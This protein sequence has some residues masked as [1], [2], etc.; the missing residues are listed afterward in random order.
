MSSGGGVFV[1][2]TFTGYLGVEIKV[3]D[4]AV[5][6][7]APIRGPQRAEGFDLA[8]TSA[9]TMLMSSVLR[10]HTLGF[11]LNMAVF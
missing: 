5:G 9:M 1:V 3:F 4:D 7:F 2:V 11:F 8:L 6:S 10:W